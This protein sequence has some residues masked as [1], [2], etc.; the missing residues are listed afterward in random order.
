[1]L[2][3]TH[4]DRHNPAQLTT[5]EWLVTNGL[6]GYASGTVSG[7]LTRRYHGLL[8]AAVKPPVDRMLMATSLIETTSRGALDPQM[9]ESFTL[10]G[11]IP[12]WRWQL[13]DSRVEKRI[14]MRHGENTSYVRYRLEGNAPLTLT[15]ILLA[16]ARDHH[17]TTPSQPSEAPRVA[18]WSGG[19]RAQLDDSAP[20]LWVLC[21][22]AEVR[23]LND[24]QPITPLALEDERG[25]DPNDGHWRVAQ[26]TITLMPETPVTL[27]L[28]AEPTPF[29][30]GDAA[31]D[32]HRARERA[33]V[34]RAGLIDSSELMQQ[35]ACAADQFIVRR[36]LAGDTEAGYSVIAGYPWFGDWGRDTMIALPGLTLAVGRPAIAR[37]VIQTYARYVDQGML[38]NRFPE[39]SETPD[40]NTADAT[41]WYFEAV[42][43]YFEATNDLDTLTALFPIL[44]D[45]I[46]WH[47][48]GTRY[49]I[50][51]DPADG[52]LHVGVEGVNLTWMDAKVEGVVMTPRTGKP[53]E[54]NALWLNALHSMA[55]FAVRLGEDPS[56]YRA[57]AAQAEIGFARFWNPDTGWCYDVLDPADP[58]LRP[59]Q[60]IAAALPHT[61]LTV[62]QCR[63]IVDAC[64][65][66][67]LTPYGLRSL[68]PD[69]PDYRGR[70]VGDWRTRD[71]MYHQGP[72]WSWL[73]GPYLT[74]HW[75]AYADREAIV[76]IFEAALPHMTQ[77]CIGQ[78][79]EIFDGDAPHL[80][81]GAFAQA[82]GVA[83]L[84]RV[85]HAV[86][87]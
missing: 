17:A 62:E 79:S 66:S 26:L 55:D 80:P 7:V 4:D 12:T 48:R 69:D 53:V 24:W 59:N 78:I 68:P 10:E 86:L 32:E 19:L 33:L 85:W 13:A 74:A 42:R 20:A 54:I 56:E 16:S 37:S 1:M 46:A 5:S 70:Y 28:S 14:W 57:R 83:E 38:P 40:Y 51:V 43:A 82:W 65:A 45:I 39:G 61:P 73:I 44:A 71:R 8:V 31:L 18:L 63:T 67:L 77:G 72:V 22:G 9:L 11:T 47:V 52:L 27:I 64:S 75:R 23:L 21:G 84:L 29:V 15:L 25:F 41:L 87:K 36:P 81:R 34:G 3:L 30:D 49:D 50:H 60:L 58:T 2:R 6:G 35:L 76:R